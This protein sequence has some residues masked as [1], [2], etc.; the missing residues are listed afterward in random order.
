MSRQPDALDPPLERTTQLLYK[1][2]HP[3]MV[4]RSAVVRVA[5]GADAGASCA[6]DLEPIRVGAGAGNQLVLSDAMT[7]R[8]HLE[9]QVHDRGYLVRDLDSTN[10]TFYRGARINE[11]L[12]GP[13]AEIRLGET[14]LRIERGEERSIT[15]VP[16]EAFGSLIGTSRPMQEVFGILAAV[17]PTDSTVMIEGETGTGQELVAREIHLQSPRAARELVV[18]DCGSIPSELI[19][20]ELFGHSKGAFTGAVSDRAGV[21][22]QAAGGTVFL[23]EL[24]ELP[25]ELQTRLLRVL[26][27]RTVS[28]LG[29]HEPRKVDFRV[30]AATH[31]DLEQLVKEGRFR[32][33]LFYRLGVVK[34]RL[35]P[36]RERP[37]D[38]P[39]LARAFLRRN[40][41]PNPDAVLTPEVLEALCSRQWP[42]NVR[43]LRNVLE[44]AMV[45]G[46]G[47]QDIARM[48]GA[49]P[50]GDEETWVA[51][52]MPQRW[53]DRPYKEVKE[54]LLGQ[55][56]AHYFASLLERHGY[57]I[58]RIASGAG[59]DR[60]LVRK[61]LRKHD[62]SREDQP[63]NE[64]DP[65]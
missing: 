35:P 25:L 41:C 2:Q 49:P 64:R 29:T 24:G 26:D 55:F 47:A 1:D 34:V 7:S 59:V 51:Q 30:V 4:L 36:L 3:V 19:E 37:E 17:A 14:V 53:L 40:A 9:L 65:G 6:L 44:R 12:I 62:M 54:Q 5:S 38:I 10:G 45:L 39:T 32:E 57:N 18:V 15:L 23:D 48:P 56:E 27:Q 28:R 13:G 61:L 22:E 11:V 8:E 33:D 21:F 20:S 16:R 63:D 43:E 31:R 58:S 52:A 50:A 46:D 60:H 42:G